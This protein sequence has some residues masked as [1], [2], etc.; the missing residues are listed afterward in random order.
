[1]TAHEINFDGIVGPTHNYGGLARGNIA[2]Q[3][4]VRLASNPKAAARQGLRKMKMLHDLGVPQAVLPAQDRPAVEVLR[5]LGFD[6]KEREVLRKAWRQSPGLLAACASASSMWAANAATVCPSAD[7]RDGRVHFTPANLR[8]HFHRQIEAPMTARVLRQIFADPELFVHHAALP[9]AELFGDEGAANH[10]RLCRRYGEPGTQM[11]VYGRRALAPGPAPSLHPARQ[12]LEA[13]QAVSRLH[14]LTDARVVFAQQHPAAID[15]GAFHNDVVAVAN[16]N[17]LLFHHGAFLD[18]EQVKRDL[19]DAA[20]FDLHLIEV[21]SENVSIEDAVASY[22]FNSQLVTLPSGRMALVVPAECQAAATVWTFLA[23]L[24]HDD[25][26]I[27][28]VEVTDVRQSMQNGG[29]PACLRL[30][31]VLTTEEMRRMHPPLLLDESLFRRLDDWV[32]RHYR[33]RLEE[34]DLADPQLLDESRAAL[35][36]LT[37]ILDLPGLY[38][39]QR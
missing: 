26:F 31:V 23:E 30:R 18:P 17:V 2:S 39:F 36:E 12:T 29:G 38:D 16:R 19:C 20:D 1:M 13:S 25:P 28:R 35:D 4:N 21:A 9:P 14:G 6:G 10:S 27:E 15:A 8:S 24:V 32:G 34:P 37:Q 11:F 22:L 3:R 33:D 7:S 5:A